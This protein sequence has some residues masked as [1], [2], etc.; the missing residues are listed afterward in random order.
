[1]AIIRDRLRDLNKFYEIL[2]K[3]E[4]KVGGKRILSGCDAGMDWPR[5][6]I[7]F[8]FENGEFTHNSDE[9]RVVRIGTHALKK[10]SGTT[11]WDRL[12]G[13]KGTQKGKYPGGGNHRGSVFR[14]HVGNAIIKREGIKCE[15][16]GKGTSAGAEVRIKEHP[17][18]IRVSK[19]IGCMPFVWVKVDDEPGPNSMRKYIERHSIGLLSNYM[20]PSINHPSSSWLGRYC[21]NE[22]VR[23][24]GLWNVDHVDENYDPSFLDDLDH[25]VDKMGD[26][27]RT[28][29]KHGWNPKLNIKIGPFPNEKIVLCSA[30][31]GP[32][33]QRNKPY[34]AAHF[35][36]GGKWVG[37]VRNTAEELGIRFVILTTG[38][39]M[40]DPWDKISPY[41]RHIDGYTKEVN[42]K[43]VDT[44]PRTLGTNQYNILVFYA[45]GCPRES[46]LELMMPILNSLNISM[47]TF[48]RPNMYDIDKIEEIVGSLV[49]GSNLEEMKS[50]MKY[51]KRLEWYPTGDM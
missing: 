24:S 40:V 4:H 39:G 16:W 26:K 50:I 34:E 42:E 41:D 5:Q 11:L 9:L 48:G 3:I 21:T 49:E 18:E 23:N 2:K 15:S 29:I 17:L 10:N 8:F 13:H 38:H 47:I 35:F 32:G 1:M 43:W 14:L 33:S 37:A 31:A 51:P 20:R 30:D 25:F 44:I 27:K 12:K 19:T 7:Y 28:N 6:G 46:Y 22:K 45:G 36:P